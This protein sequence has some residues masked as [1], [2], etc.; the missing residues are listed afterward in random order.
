MNCLFYNGLTPMRGR[1]L[2]ANAYFPVGT[3]LFQMT[4]SKGVLTPMGALVHNSR[5]ANIIC[6]QAA[7]GLYAIAAVP[8][9]PG[10]Q[11]LFNFKN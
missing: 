7:D 9:Y 2:Y 4:D 1:G 6:R 3:T 8:I 11:I 5:L 10:R